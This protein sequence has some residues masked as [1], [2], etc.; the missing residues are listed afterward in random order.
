M[1]ILTPYF[2]ST[3]PRG[4][5]TVEFLKIAPLDQKLLIFEVELG[6]AQRFPH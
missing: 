1:V 4:S 3:G 2:K 6:L 5:G